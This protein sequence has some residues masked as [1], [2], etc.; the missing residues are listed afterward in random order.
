[1]LKNIRRKLER[2]WR[3]SK[4]PADRER[5]VFQKG[6]VNNEIALAKQDHYSSK[7]QENS[8]NTEFFSRTVEKLLNSNP[9]QRYTSG[10]DNLTESFVDF[11]N[12]KTVRD[13]KYMK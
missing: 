12:N 9:V 11:F 13:V 7:I 1:M 6:V 10:T 4:L 2:K 8:G 5:Y 3:S